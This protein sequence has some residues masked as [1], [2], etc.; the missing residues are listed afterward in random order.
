MMCICRSNTAIRPD[1][2]NVVSDVLSRDSLPL[3][4][5]VAP[6]PLRALHAN[7][8]FVSAAKTAHTSVNQ[9]MFPTLF[10]GRFVQPARKD[11]FALVDDAIHIQ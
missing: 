8:L 2:E 1:F 10:K 5:N 7:R 9:R 4:I 6:M 11:H 3:H